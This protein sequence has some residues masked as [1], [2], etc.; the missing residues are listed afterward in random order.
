[1]Q[2]SKSTNTS[3]STGVRLNKIMATEILADQKEY[4]SMIG[5]LMYAILATRP[6]LA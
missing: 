6:D 3:L 4:Q 2:D 1:M 5:N